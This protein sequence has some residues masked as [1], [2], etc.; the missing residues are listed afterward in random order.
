[1]M[2]R[3][4][5]FVPLVFLLSSLVFEL[6]CSGGDGEGGSGGSGGVAGAGGSAGSGGN[7][8]MG[9]VGGMPRTCMNPRDCNDNEPC[10]ADLCVA[11]VCQY[12]PIPNQTVCLSDTGLSACLA[13]VCQLIWPSCDDPGAEDGDFCQPMPTPEPARLGRCDAGACVVDPCEIGFDCWNGDAC[14]V[15]ICDDAEGTCMQ[16]NAPDGRACIPPA[17]GTCAGGV[18]RIG[19]GGTG[20]QGGAGGLGGQGGVGGQGGGGGL[21]G[22]DGS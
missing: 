12:E 6:G 18:C 1:M 7:G 21:G 17:G 11:Q 14:S 4:L 15:G 10:T 16:E 20:G 2:A 9:G 5:R 8:G 22:V 19:S 13:G 3:M